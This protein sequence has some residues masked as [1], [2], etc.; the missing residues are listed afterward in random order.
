MKTNMK[1]IVSLSFVL[2][3]I[4]IIIFCRH[5]PLDVLEDSAI[6]RKLSII[7]IEKDG[8]HEQV[9]NLA[10]HKNSKVKDGGDANYSKAIELL[11]EIASETEC[12]VDFFNSSE[13]MVKIEKIYGIGKLRNEKANLKLVHALTPDG[14]RELNQD[15]I[16][17]TYTTDHEKIEIYR[18]LQVAIATALI[19]S[20]SKE[21]NLELK[22]IYEQ[23]KVK[24]TQSMEVFLADNLHLSGRDFREKYFEENPLD[25][26]YQSA[27]TMYMCM[28]EE[29]EEANGDLNVLENENDDN[30]I[31][32]NSYEIFV[33]Y[34][35]LY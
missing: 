28:L 19:Y 10:V 25:F 30:F 14:I 17:K 13:L 7:N 9:E 32:S 21:V 31:D 33:R 2:L 18:N 16:N 5:V 15:W 26:T 8:K 35:Y 24:Y 23:N 12:K 29:I 1:K 6:D 34:N 11:A 20:G 3:A 22:K 4:A 27:V